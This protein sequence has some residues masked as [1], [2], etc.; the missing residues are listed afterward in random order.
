MQKLKLQFFVLAVLVGIVV[1]LAPAASSSYKGSGLLTV[2]VL[3]IGQGDA[4][5]IEA[6]NGNQALFDAGNGDEI[7]SK[8]REVM[9]AGD[10][11]INVALATNPDRDHIGGFASVF[12]TYEVGVVFEPGTVSTTKTYEAF[13]KASENE[14]SKYYLARKG[15]R[16]TL[17]QEKGVY[18]DILFPDR[19]VSKFER[20]D[21]SIVAK[22]TY[23]ATSFLL[24]GDSTTVTEGL[25][26]KSSP[27]L[28][29]VDVLKVGH[30][31]SRTSTS[32]ELLRLATPKYAAISYGEGNSYG[33]PHLEVVERL[34]KHG[35]EVHGTGEEGT[36]V[37]VSD[38]KTVSVAQD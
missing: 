4:I 8:L 24:T 34:K 17:D 1:T 25:I 2:A 6:P 20:N 5:Y 21:G 35:V 27:E 32:E 28:L 23:G 12:E 11:S 29:D 16:I 18:I 3:D 22:L 31:G 19:D 38:G 37:F 33:H 9:H 13:Q 14:G 26:A 15:T 7:I 36:I 10:D 30:H